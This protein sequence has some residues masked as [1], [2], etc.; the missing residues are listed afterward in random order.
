MHLNTKIV[1][2]LLYFVVECTYSLAV[3]MERDTFP[4]TP[5]APFLPLTG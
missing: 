5:A 2:V 1:V 4:F 3:A